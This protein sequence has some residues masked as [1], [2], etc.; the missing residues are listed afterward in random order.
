[1]WN[2]VICDDQTEIL[3]DVEQ[4]QNSLKMEEIRSIICF[5]YADFMIG[6]LEEQRFDA[7]IFILDVKLKEM[8]GIDLA[9]RILRLHPNSQIIFMSGYDDYFEDAYEVEHCFF[10]RKPVT[11]V[12][13][14]KAVRRAIKNLGNKKKNF[15]YVENKSGQYVI[16]C[17]EIFIIERRK[18]KLLVMGENGKLLCSFYG[19]LEEAGARLPDHFFQC[20]NSIL[21][22]FK[23]ARSI[24]GE[25]FLMID[26][27]R[28]V[29]SRSHKNECK[30]SF[31]RFCSE[32]CAKAEAKEE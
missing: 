30:S 13:L 10:L 18:R 5:Q 24:S 28:V 20:H 32:R 2:V 19:K 7:D 26:G 22:N 1:M 3:R 12:K 29:I 27:S 15:F 21:V 17:S 16:D 4:K 14:E 9:R 31:A 6:E 8:N 11:V 23:K 25:A